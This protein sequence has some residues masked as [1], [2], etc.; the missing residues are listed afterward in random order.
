MEEL[1]LHATS[2]NHGALL[3]TRVFVLQ[4]NTGQ[5]FNVL[6]A[7]LI[8]TGMDLLVFHVWVAKYGIL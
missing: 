3:P 7:N 5:D 4:I 6:F 2:V 8:N 1:A